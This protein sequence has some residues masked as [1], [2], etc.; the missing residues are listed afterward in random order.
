M[1]ETLFKKY[2]NVDIF[3]RT[4]STNEAHIKILMKFDFE[5]MSV[6]KNDRG[7]GIDTVY[8]KKSAKNS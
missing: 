5:I 7:E 1:Y 2:E 4:W 6:L 3:T 8:F